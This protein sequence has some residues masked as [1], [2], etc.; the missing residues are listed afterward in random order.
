MY[1]ASMTK[2]EFSAF[3]KSVVSEAINEERKILRVINK[4]DDAE[5][6]TIEKVT[7]KF[8]VTKATVHNWA[9]ASRI[10]KYKINGRTLFKLAEIEQVFA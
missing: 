5:Y 8:K 6:C 4:S 1:I 9:K 7:E 3:I 2:S 10:R